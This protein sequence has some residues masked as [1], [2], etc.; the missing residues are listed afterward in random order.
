AGDGQL[1][2]DLEA[3]M[4]VPRGAAA[5]GQPKT[6]SESVCSTACNA[7]APE[8]CG[9]I[10]QATTVRRDQAGNPRGQRRSARRQRL[11]A[12][13]RLFPPAAPPPDR[14]RTRRDRM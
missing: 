12:D 14:R 6:A 7:T 11:R 13:V 3:R 4:W 1:A 8:R 2:Y 10:R 9:S 5:D